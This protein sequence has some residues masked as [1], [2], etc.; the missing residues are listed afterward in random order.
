MMPS[1]FRVDKARLPPCI[2]LSPLPVTFC[3]A[4][5]R[6]RRRALQRLRELG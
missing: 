2:A 4:S 1:R 5:L 3:S 6:Y